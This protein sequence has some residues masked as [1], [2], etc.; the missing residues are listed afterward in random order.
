MKYHQPYGSSDP[1]E[2]YV[3]RDLA[4]G[5]QGSRVPA[6]AVEQPMREIVAAIT[7]AGLTPSDVD[8]GQLPQAIPLLAPG[9]LMD[10][11]IFTASGTYTP[12]PGTKAVLVEVQGGGGAGG[13]TQST[14]SGSFAA[15]GTGGAAGGFAAS[16]LTSGFSGVSVTVGAGGTGVTGGNGNNGGN[17][18]FGALLSATG[19][20]GGGVGTNVSV[21]NA[22]QPVGGVVGGVGTGG[23]LINAQGGLGRYALLASSPL[24]GEGG[25]SYFGAG[26]YYR[27]STSGGLAAVTPGS[28]GS[29]ASSLSGNPS[30]VIGGPGAAGI[31]RI[32]EFA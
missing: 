18:A 29:G 31:V 5:I 11:R 1:D 12:T 32:W 24:S 2:S 23:N 26:A 25:S 15:A 19:G 22:A 6:K 10:V 16:Y 20:P 3:N 13:G 7:A 27:S 17:S 14:S 4:S 21:S 8:L 30:G 9:R 28:G